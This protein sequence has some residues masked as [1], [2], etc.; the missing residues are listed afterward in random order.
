MIQTDRMF[1]IAN[2]TFSGVP[3]E[4]KKRLTGD[5]EALGAYHGYKP[6]KY[7]VSSLDD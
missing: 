1:D 4:E 5:T 7:W 6:R 2:L 3:V